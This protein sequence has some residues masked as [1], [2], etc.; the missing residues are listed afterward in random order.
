LRDFCT[1]Q[2]AFLALLPDRPVFRVGQIGSEQ[3]VAI[4][5]RICSVSRASLELRNISHCA[6]IVANA[7]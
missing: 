4:L 6:D 1:I 2:S 5:V 3:Q 7:K